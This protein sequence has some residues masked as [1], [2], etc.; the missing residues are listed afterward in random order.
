MI[1]RSVTSC[2]C[3]QHKLSLLRIRNL[4]DIPSDV[5][6]KTLTRRDSV[7][8]TVENSPTTDP[9]QMT[10]YNLLH[11]LSY[12]LIFQLEYVTSD[13]PTDSPTTQLILNPSNLTIAVSTNSTKSFGIGITFHYCTVYKSDKYPL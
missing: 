2:S 13:I 8:F 3:H 10:T 6:N 9:P 11:K 12:V 7:T 1:C 5:P 4:T